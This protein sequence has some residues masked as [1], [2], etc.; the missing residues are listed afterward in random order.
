MMKKWF[1]AFFLLGTLALSAADMKQC[2]VTVTQD[3]NG[4]FRFAPT[5]TGKVTDLK[6]LPDLLRAGKI[7]SV[8]LSCWARCPREDYLPILE[9]LRNAEISVEMC[10]ILVPERKDWDRIDIAGNPTKIEPEPVQKPALTVRPIADNA[11]N[12]RYKL[13]KKF[14]SV[15]FI[16]IHNTAE[17]YTAMQERDRVD[18]RRDKSPVSFHFAVDEKE[19]VQ[20][21]PMSIHGWHAGD[22]SKGPGNTR[23]IG[24]E[25]CRSQCRDNVD[26]LYRRS[27]ANAVVLAAALLRKY[28]LT[29]EALRMHYDWNKKFCPHRI[30][31][32]KRFEDLKKRVA[33]LMEKET[34]SILPVSDLKD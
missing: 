30:L 25:I 33:L 13:P 32:E 8:I 19:A 1:S 15:D 26:M 4:N 23:S 31:E 22:G 3:K 18:F 34:G 20:I 24:I 7:R 5:F 21:L 2:G 27:E 29:P 17:P 9:T 12:R 14:Q 6:G 10:Y 28:Q 11:Y 16:T